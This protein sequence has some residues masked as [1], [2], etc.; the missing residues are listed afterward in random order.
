MLLSVDSFKQGRS[1]ISALKSSI[2]LN[3]QAL[4]NMPYDMIKEIDDIEYLLTMSEF[5]DEEDCEV[6]TEKAMLKIE[7]WL[8]NVPS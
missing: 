2:E 3:G 1:S 5:A 8:R 4:E 6:E 7:S